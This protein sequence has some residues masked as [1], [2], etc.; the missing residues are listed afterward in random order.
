MKNLNDYIFLEDTT[1]PDIDVRNNILFGQGDWLNF[2]FGN[3]NIL[4]NQKNINL[5]RINVSDYNNEDKF[6]T[7]YN[8][9]WH[10]NWYSALKNIHPTILE[11]VKQGKGKLVFL[12]HLE[13]QPLVSDDSNL[14]FLEPMY[15]ELNKLNIPPNNI[16]YITANCIATE[17]HNLW[18][19]KNK[20]YERMNVIGIITESIEL[21]YDVYKGIV[22][23]NHTF[24]EHFNSVK[25][26]SNLRHWLK[27]HRNDRHFKTIITHHLWN[28]ELIDTIHTHHRKYARHDIGYPIT[29]NSKT[30]IW[31][32]KLLSTKKE[33]EKTLPYFIQDTCEE[34]MID[35][36]SDRDFTKNMYL[37]SLFN[38]YPSSW[39]FFRNAAF[40]RHGVPFHIWEY[41]PFLIYGNVNTLQ[42]LK[43]RGFETFSEIF[44][45]S[46][47][48]IDDDGLRLKMVC[49]EVERISRLPLED[50]INLYYSVKDKLIY[51]RKLL[52]ENIE[53]K[54][55]MEHFCEAI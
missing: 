53:L 13:G 24:D 31:L 54:R 3:L 35:F 26:S 37:D 7:L 29:K 11:G 50:A 52:E 51:N 46:Y 27:P 21:K 30:K 40:L 9:Y 5:P 1:L 48:T 10:Q 28:N 33:F 44:D 32:D 43:E 8:C 41:Q 4:L 2:I 19:E 55:F 16:I 49:E 22:L 17:E 45:E 47:D 20:V 6:L 38:V 39:P 12:N 34:Q 42:I 15:K 36:D 18:C 25:N 14:N 23:N